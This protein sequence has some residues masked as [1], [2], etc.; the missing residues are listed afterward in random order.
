M[1]KQCHQK[2]L[3]AQKQEE[4]LARYKES[5]GDANGA[6]GPE[7][8]KFESYKRPSQLPSKIDELRIVVD[9]RNQTVIVPIY[10]IPV[11]FHISTLRN[12]SKNDEGDYIYLR[13]NFITP[14]QGIGKQDAMV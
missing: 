1:I 11:P 13:L 6:A 8:K 12:A 10:G 3:H 4:G 9:T 7:V 14:G 5:D 2:E